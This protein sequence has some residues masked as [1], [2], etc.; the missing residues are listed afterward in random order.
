MSQTSPVASLSIELLQ[1]VLS[2]LPDV[3]SLQAAATSCRAFHHAFQ[4]AQGIIA[5]LVLSNQ[6]DISVLPEAIAADT[7]AAIGSRNVS[8]IMQKLHQRYDR[9]CST[10]QMF[11][12]GRFHHLVSDLA[13]RFATT[14]I[15]AF[16]PH[17]PKDAISLREKRRIERSIYRFEI[18]CNLFRS[19]DM[20]RE[21]QSSFFSRLAPWE[22]EQLG[23]IHD[24]LVR[25]VSPAFDDVAE[26]DVFWGVC[27]VTYGVGVG[28]PYTQHLLSHGVAKIQEIADTETYADRWKLLQGDKPAKPN[29]DFLYDGLL[30]R[31]NGLNSDVYLD[32][33]T[34]IE[35][36]PLFSDADS[37][38]EDAWR[39]AHF[40]EPRA[41]WIYQAGRD[42]L[43]AWGYVMWD[44]S[45]LEG[46]GIFSKAWQDATDRQSE[47]REAE[48]EHAYMQNS[49]EQREWV[50]R[51]GGS[52]WWSWGDQSKV[53]W[54]GKVRPDWSKRSDASNTANAHPHIKPKSLSE[55]RELLSMIKLPQHFR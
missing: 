32:Q 35:N 51:Q 5:T 38:P 2:Y 34:Q 4:G 39:W 7:S 15:S 12:L 53:I 19:S 1:S 50:S 27:H 6:I 49:W 54:E 26:H 45:R 18:F 24:F 23:C 9:P 28:S 55:A 36:G 41:N 20:A 37:G 16:E 29:H 13:G 31:A 47:R 33:E 11:R 21:E 22:N 40:D 44:S 43:R 46:F 10:R 52:G 17:W 14:V 48:R 8:D 25:L 42:K 3:T 30:E